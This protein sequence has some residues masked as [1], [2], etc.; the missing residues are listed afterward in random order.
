MKQG[1]ALKN[2]RAAWKQLRKLKVS[3]A[4]ARAEPPDIEYAEDVVAAKRALWT[5]YQD[6]HSTGIDP[7]GVLNHLNSKT[8]PWSR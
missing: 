5:A 6:A 8:R 3:H 1:Q 2:L 4:E 7:T